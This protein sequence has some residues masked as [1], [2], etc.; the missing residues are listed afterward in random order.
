VN[1]A[2]APSPDE[3]LRSAMDVIFYFYGLICFVI[4]NNNANTII[5]P[6]FYSAMSAGTAI[7]ALASAA[8]MMLL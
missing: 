2:I 8:A 7:S 4:T 5:L 1:L 6:F 3:I